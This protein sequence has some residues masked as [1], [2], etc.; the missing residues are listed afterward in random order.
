MGGLADT[1]GMR[2]R[3]ELY[4]PDR[5]AELLDALMEPF[6]ELSTSREAVAVVAEVEELDDE[7]GAETE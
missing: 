6:A 7:A 5:I 3:A 2:L 1:Q 4:E